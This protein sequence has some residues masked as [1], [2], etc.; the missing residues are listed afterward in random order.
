MSGHNVTT[1]TQSALIH[2][3][4]HVETN[5]IKYVFVCSKYQHGPSL[6]QC[7][8]RETGVQHGH[9][10]DS[11]ASRLSESLG[12]NGEQK[13][14]PH[15]RRSDGVWQTETAQPLMNAGGLTL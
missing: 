6:K 3:T 12:W 8:S 2:Y 11:P 4:V 7:D 14:C 9:M 5:H 15:Q 1:F 13:L 10:R